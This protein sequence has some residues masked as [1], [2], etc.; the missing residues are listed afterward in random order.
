MHITDSLGTTSLRYF[1]TLA[2][3]LHFGRAAARLRIAQPFLS[4]KIRAL[5]AALGTPLF[6]RSTR[7]VELTDAGALFLETVRR[8][9]GDLERSTE[10]LHALGRGELGLVRVGY[11]IIGTL[12][13]IPDLVRRFRIGYPAV[14][15]ALDQAS[16]PNQV[17]RLL[18]GDLDLGFLGQPADP[19]LR[20]H[21][22]WSESF[23]AVLPSEHPLARRRAVRLRQ[24]ERET[25]VGISRASSPL[26]YDRLAHELRHAGVTLTARQETGSFMAAVSLVAAGMGV[27]IAPAC[28]TRFRV[29]RVRYRPLAGSSPTYGLALCSTDRPLSPA[30]RSFLESCAS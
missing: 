18:R 16:T 21:L 9:L 14:R 6:R 10:E 7:R 30:A 3:E 8:T 25:Y 2:D 15:L 22:E 13:V 19:R 1:V 27:T 20:V 23:C 17:E 24:L 28:L 4:Q 11:P 5:E 12:M 29:P 26:M